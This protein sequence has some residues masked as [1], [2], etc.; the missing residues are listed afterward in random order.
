MITP[1]GNNLL[2]NDNG[3]PGNAKARAQVNCAQVS[4]CT[5]KLIVS[6]MLLA[7]WLFLMY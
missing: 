7:F 3:I 6:V 5:G 4:L 1:K 2:P